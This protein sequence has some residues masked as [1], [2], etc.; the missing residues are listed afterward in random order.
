MRSGRPGGDTQRLIDQIRD[1]IEN[2]KGGTPRQKQ[3]ALELLEIAE[4]DIW[5]Q[6][7]SE[8]ADYH[9]RI[10]DHIEKLT[11]FRLEW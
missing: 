1:Q 9:R 7:E 8:W 11:G 10:G 3:M 2:G 6:S 5:C 4:S